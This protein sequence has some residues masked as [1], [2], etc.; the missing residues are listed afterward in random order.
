MG[1]GRHVNGCGTA[2]ANTAGFVLAFVLLAAC[3]GSELLSHSQPAPA[4]APPPA[5]QEP[6]PA[7]PPPVD[8]AGRWKLSAAAASCYMN[9]ANSPGGAKAV[10]GTIAPEGGCPGNFFTSRKWRF[11]FGTLV[12]LDFKDQPLA[13]LSYSGDH[14]EGQDT[15][16]GALT[17]SR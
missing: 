17:L 12:I 3:S 5:E 16:G 1:F 7:P 13:K 10:T 11:D 14:F 6:E 4:T 15:G 8:L 9:F 2:A